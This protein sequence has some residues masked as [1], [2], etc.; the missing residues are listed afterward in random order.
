VAQ[1]QLNV[2]QDFQIHLPK[3]NGPV[4]K[5]FSG[6]QRKFQKAFP[7]LAHFFHMVDRKRS[8]KVWKIPFLNRKNYSTIP[9]NISLTGALSSVG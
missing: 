2:Y 4:Q 5:G 9:N 7:C 1:E 6:G 3:D 8:Q